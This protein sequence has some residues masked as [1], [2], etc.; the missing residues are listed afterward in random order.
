MKRTGPDRSG[1]APQ[2]PRSPHPATESNKRSRDC[3]EPAPSIH[4]P[5]LPPPPP[6]GEREMAGPCP[7]AEGVNGAAPSSPAPP[8]GGWGGGS[9]M[10]RPG[11]TRLTRTAVAPSRAARA[12][13]RARMGRGRGVRGE[14]SLSPHAPQPRP[15]PP[16][17]PSPP[18]S[19]PQ[20][21]A[22]RPPR[23]S[24]RHPAVLRPRRPSARPPPGLTM[25]SSLVT[26]VSMLNS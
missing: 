21:T 14:R 15:L 19:L 24:N 25:V 5:T 2:R 23:R 10:D 17:L 4:P 9:R 6:P 22:P 13:L 18:F 3:A 12:P 16:P 11:R 8:G 20:A 7:R 1:R 26:A